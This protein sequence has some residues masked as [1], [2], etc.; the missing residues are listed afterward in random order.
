[1]TTYKFRTG[2]STAA[3]KN[4]AEEGKN[5]N[6]IVRMLF[7]LGNQADDIVAKANIAGGA[8]DTKNSVLGGTTTAREQVAADQ[9]SIATQ[10]ARLKENPMDVGAGI[11]LVRNLIKTRAPEMSPEDAKK[12]AELVTSKNAADVQAAMVDDGQLSKLSKIVDMAIYGGSRLAA[13]GSKPLGANVQE[14]RLSSSG[15]MD[16]VSGAVSDSVGNLMQSN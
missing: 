14:E 6:E 2:S 12:L 3:I 13:S 15:L 11:A 5:F 1:M 4:V 7:P 9:M 10:T 16:Y 8:L